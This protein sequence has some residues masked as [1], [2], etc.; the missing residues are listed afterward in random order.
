MRRPYNQ[1]VT[2]K[3]SA[4]NPYD[5]DV[6]LIRVSGLVEISGVGVLVGEP[7]LGCTVAS[8]IQGNEVDLTFPASDDDFGLSGGCFGNYALEGHGLVPG[9]RTAQMVKIFRVR[10]YFQAPFGI[11]DYP[12]KDGKPVGADVSSPL[13]ED[14]LSL[15]N[16][17]HELLESFAT[18]VM[19]TARL[20][21]FDQYWIGTSVGLTRLIGHRDY[22]DVDSDAEIPYHSVKWDSL[23]GVIDGDRPLDSELMD[24]ILR[25]VSEGEAP[26]FAKII[27][28]DAHFLGRVRLPPDRR[29]S[30]VLATVAVE[31][32]IQEVLRQVCPPGSERLLELLTA[33]PR[34]F[35]VAIFSHLDKTLDALVGRSL[36]REYRETWRAVVKLF[37]LRNRIVHGGSNEVT[38]DETIASVQAAFSTFEWLDL[39][40]H[41]PT[42]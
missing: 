17:A 21:P 1:G 33:S 28:T 25:R 34:D 9:P 15:T 30:V 16:R 27:L 19:S 12:V 2:R 13:F 18:E 3:C 14:Q 4:L 20:A 23:R 11:G 24:S 26:N 35:S 38:E 32:H 5:A 22:F 36:K 42:V 40:L 7:M 39:V 6:A 29:M 8:T 37:E 41:P 10:V 31:T